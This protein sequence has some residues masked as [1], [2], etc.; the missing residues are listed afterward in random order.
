MFHMYLCGSNL[1]QNYI[2]ERRV[3]N[4]FNAFRADDFEDGDECR[5]EFAA[6]V[7]F[8]EK[9]QQAQF[10]FSKMRLRR[11]FSISARVISSRSISSLISS[12]WRSTIF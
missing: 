5:D 2:A 12:L 11:L 10:L 4:K 7:H 6:R 9:F 8:L 1:P 3:L